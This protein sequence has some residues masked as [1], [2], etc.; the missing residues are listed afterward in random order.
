MK[1]LSDSVRIMRLMSLSEGRH[2][3]LHYCISIACG[4]HTYIN[5]YL[6]Q[7]MQRSAAHIH[8]KHMY[9]HMN[10]LLQPAASL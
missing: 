3:C 8:L 6:G 9:M 5:T 1:R 7:R 10:A 2:T 4:M